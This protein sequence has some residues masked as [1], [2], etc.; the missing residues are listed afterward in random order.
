MLNSS[1]DL[2]LD[3]YL[4]Y[5]YDLSVVCTSLYNNYSSFVISSNSYFPSQPRIAAKNMNDV[6]VYPY[7]NPNLNREL[8]CFTVCGFHS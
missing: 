2:E 8:I 4:L 5:K 3:Q 7:N 6:N 1:S